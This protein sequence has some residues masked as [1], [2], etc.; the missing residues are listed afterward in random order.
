MSDAMELAAPVAEVREV[1]ETFRHH[2]LVL[3]DWMDT[4]RSAIEA[5]SGGFRFAIPIV[6]PDEMVSELQQLL[7]EGLDSNPQLLDHLA[8]E[9]AQLLES[10][11]PPEVPTPSDENWAFPDSTP[12]SA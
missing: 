6:S 11:R 5:L 2:G 8:T 7:N 10:A 1:V 12:N 9:T 3:P 4:V